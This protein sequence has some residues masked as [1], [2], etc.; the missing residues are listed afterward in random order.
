VPVWKIQDT[1]LICPPVISQWAAVG[2]MQAGRSYCRDKLKTTG[3]IR[4]MFLD[5]MDDI[6]DLVTVPRAE[7]A[8]YFLLRIHKNLDP[9]TLVRRLIEEYK[10]AVIPGTTFGVQ[11]G[12]T[13]RIAYGALKKDTA[14][15]A[16][17]RLVKGLKNIL[18]T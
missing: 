12:C 15:E 10:V 6:A 1:V 18:T 17:G 8:F 11:D 9:M 16:I 13:L 2:A 3:E 4:R 7:G 14:A 5:A